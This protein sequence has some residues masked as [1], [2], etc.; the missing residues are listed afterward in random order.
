M[1]VFLVVL[2]LGTYAIT[3]FREGLSK[4][5]RGRIAL[6]ILF[7]FSG[8]SHFLVPEK[9]AQ[10]LPDSVPMRIEIIYVTGILEILGGIGL[11]VRPVQRLAAWALIAFLIGVLPA[12]IYSAFAHVDFGG[13]GNG[14]L[15]LLVRVPFQLFLIGWCYYFGIKLSSQIKSTMLSFKNNAEYKA[16]AK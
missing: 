12:N 1:I 10:M 2:V 6:T 3:G 5:L 15:Y 14:P 4:S 9:M 16:V 8:I 11:L 7:L 13:H